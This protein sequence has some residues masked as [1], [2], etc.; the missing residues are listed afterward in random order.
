LYL[1][2]LGSNI[3][4]LI[5][6]RIAAGLMQIN[7]L[8]PFYMSYIA[9]A[10]VLILVTLVVEG[11]LPNP[12]QRSE[13]YTPIPSRE[14]MDES[15]IVAADRATPNSPTTSDHEPPDGKADNQFAFTKLKGEIEVFYSLF[16]TPATFYCLA[17]MFFKRIGFASSVFAPQYVSEKFKWSLHQTTWLRV[18]GSGAAILIY[19]I[20]P[21]LNSWLIKRGSLPQIVDM[22]TIRGSLLVLGF[23]FFAAWRANS[24]A[25]MIVGRN[26]E[27]RIK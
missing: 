24:G 11:N 8:A 12:K 16:D 1:L 9:F 7:L 26:S 10:V 20:A 18:S 14:S 4:K 21:P 17:A 27:S 3:V 2:G 22:N 19:L 25:F 13:S 6:P 15:P 5:D 23:S